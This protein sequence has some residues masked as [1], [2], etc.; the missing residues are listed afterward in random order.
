MTGVFSYSAVITKLRAMYSKLLTNDD[1]EIL[2]S[3]Q[4]VTE[5]VQ[6]LKKNSQYQDILKTI[7]ESEIHRGDIERIFWGTLYKDAEGLEKMLS[8][9]K[10]G[11]LKYFFQDRRLIY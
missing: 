7:P 1:Y 4:S 5:I 10:N 2:M 3:Q 9:K 11:C 8:A 6:W